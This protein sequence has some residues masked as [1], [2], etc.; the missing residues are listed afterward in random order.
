M[1]PLEKKGETRVTAISG[2]L[3]D[4]TV[5]IR[6]EEG[7]PSYC[8]DDKASLTN[9]FDSADDSLSSYDST[10]FSIRDDMKTLCSNVKAE[11][12]VRNYISKC[13][14][15]IGISFSQ[16]WNVVLSHDLKKAYSLMGTACIK[17]VE[18]Q[19]FSLN[20]RLQKIKKH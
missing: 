17:G 16:L 8:L 20:E 15:E 11:R 2:S 3:S 18:E 6:C 13:A 12:E 7:N 1:I 4:T 5:L 10:C 19:F 14:D 9:W